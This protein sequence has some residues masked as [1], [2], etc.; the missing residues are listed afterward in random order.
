MSNEWLEEL[1]FSS[2]VICL[3]SSSILIHCIINTDQID[4]LYS[5][6]VLINIVS[7]SLTEYLL[8]DM[9]L[10]PTMK[11]MRSLLGHII[12]SSI[13]LH[14]L[15]IQVEG[16]LVHFSFYIFNTWDFDLLIGQPFR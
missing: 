4:A 10:T 12:P 16:T 5:L 6:V 3:D 15:P 7:M 8:Q 1:E 13:I 14:V 11:F 9:T 2:K